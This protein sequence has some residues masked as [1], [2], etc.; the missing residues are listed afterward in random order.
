MF[1]FLPCLRRSTRC[2]TCST[3]ASSSSPQ[4]STVCS[5]EGQ[6]CCKHWAPRQISELHNLFICCG[7]AHAEAVFRLKSNI[8]ACFG[9]AFWLSLG[10]QF[11]PSINSSWGKK[12]DRKNS[13]QHFSNICLL[14]EAYQTQ[15][16]ICFL[17]TYGEKQV[18][19]LFAQLL[20]LVET[21]FWC[22]TDDQS[23]PPSL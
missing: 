12:W 1:T 22:L 2:R 19:L 14:L 9:M 11:S 13:G 18:P 4:Q 6:G 16:F 20:L 15:I 23:T 7:S 8:F 3:H 5:Q 21:T 10:H 17:K